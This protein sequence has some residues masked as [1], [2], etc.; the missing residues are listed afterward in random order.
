MRIATA[1]GGRVFLLANKKRASKTGRMCEGGGVS[2]LL[3]LALGIVSSC[4]ALG[5]APAAAA[6]LP[7][8]V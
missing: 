2:H 3:T 5:V 6:S 4:T 7:R 1:A 8:S